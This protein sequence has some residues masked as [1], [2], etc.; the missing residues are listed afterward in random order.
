MSPNRRSKPLKTSSTTLA[1]SV[2]Q[3]RDQ[4]IAELRAAVA[5]AEATAAARAQTRTG[6]QALEQH[7]MLG[8]EPAQGK[9]LR[10]SGTSSQSSNS[11]AARVEP[12]IEPAAEVPV[13]NLFLDTFLFIVSIFCKDLRV[14]KA[15]KNMS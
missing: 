3:E 6:R 9:L 7:G 8:V 1:G 13:Q 2:L 15:L 4:L 14:W 5:K 10:S 12:P 11:A